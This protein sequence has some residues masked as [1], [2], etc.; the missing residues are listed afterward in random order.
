MPASIAR[1]LHPKHCE[2]RDDVDI[3]WNL[4]DLRLLETLNLDIYSISFAIGDMV[5]A[6]CGPGIFKS[7]MF[8]F[9]YSPFM[10]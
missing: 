6:I 9:Y 8:V 1:T 5:D 3:S 2:I 4:S 7:S 10:G